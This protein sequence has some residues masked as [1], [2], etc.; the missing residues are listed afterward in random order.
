MKAIGSPARTM[1]INGAMLYGAGAVLVT[2][3]F[4]APHSQATN[5]AGMLVGAGI[6]YIV[7]AMLLLGRNWL[8]AWIFPTLTAAGTA[9]ITLLVVCDGTRPSSFMLL[10]VWRRSTPFTSTASRSRSSRRPGSPLPP[11]GAQSS[12]VPTGT[13]ASSVG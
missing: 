9:I 7:T 4:A 13:S 2:V 1:A 10:Y 3:F 5:V 6:A 11:A 8:P 12:P